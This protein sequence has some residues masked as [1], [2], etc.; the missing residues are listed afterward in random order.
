MRKRIKKISIS[1]FSYVYKLLFTILLWYRQVRNIQT[2][3]VRIILVHNNKVAL[4]RHWYQ[5][6]WVFPGG[7]IKKHEIP[8]QAA[9]RELKEELGITINQ[10]DYLLGVYSNNKQGKKDTVYC[11][12]VQLDKSI[13]FKRYIYNIEISDSDWFDIENLPQDVSRATLLRLAEYKDQSISKI[14]RNW[15]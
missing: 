12:V 7:G 8:E 3:G 6:L 10:L 11:F 4:V 9:I 2:K 15:N 13:S 1:F 5:P 14:I